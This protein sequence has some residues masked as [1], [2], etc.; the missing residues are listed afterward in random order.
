[1]FSSNLCCM[2]H[3]YVLFLSFF[4]QCVDSNADPATVDQEVQDNEGRYVDTSDDEQTET[5]S[6]VAKEGGKLYPAR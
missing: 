6:F 1:M 4:I 2:T 5:L 3:V